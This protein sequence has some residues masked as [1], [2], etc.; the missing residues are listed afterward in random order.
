MRVLKKTQKILKLNRETVAILSGMRLFFAAAIVA[1]SSLARA[2]FELMLMYDDSQ[3]IIRRYDPVNRVL[4]GSFAN[5]YT[6][7]SSIANVM[8]L[9]KS[10]PGT[11]SLMDQSGY[12]RTF[13]YSSGILV[14]GVNTAGTPL[15]NLGIRSLKF[16]N[17]GEIIRVRSGTAAPQV[18]SPLTGALIST[19]STF[20]AYTTMDVAPLADGRFITLEQSFSAGLYRYSLFLRNSSGGYISGL[21]SYVTSTDADIQNSIT[22]LGNTVFA[23]GNPGSPE[24]FTSVLTGTTFGTAVDIPSFSNVGTGSTSVEFGHQGAGY[25]VQRDT[26]STMRMYH[27]DGM[28]G[29]FGTQYAMPFTGSVTSIAVV[30]APEPMSLV[31]MG[32]GA[33]WL[34]RRRRRG[35]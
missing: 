2:S 32:V 31:A 6:G 1:S 33:A 7:F 17:S 29:F 27:V 34:V 25:L 30:N 14:N 15:I 28:A 23:S 18:F 3:D 13:D 8:A 5:G 16:T 21:L 4:L 22:M 35:N 11:V 26:G 9:N 20:S 12:V 19:W 24:I 10:R